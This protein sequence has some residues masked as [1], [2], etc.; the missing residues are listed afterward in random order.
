MR[1]IVYLLA[2]CCLSGCGDSDSSHRGYVISK[3]HLD[4]APIAPEG[5]EAIEESEL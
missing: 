3:S 4:E 5:Q 2:F 1:S